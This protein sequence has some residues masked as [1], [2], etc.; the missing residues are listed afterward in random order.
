MRRTGFAFFAVGVGCTALLVSA[1]SS[2]CRS[3]SPVPLVPEGQGGDT[4]SV[5]AHASSTTGS[6]ATTSATGAGGASGATTT[7]TTGAPDTTTVASGSGGGAAVT[8]SGTTTT[9]A[10]SGSGGSNSACTGIS[11]TIADITGAT[12]GSGVQVTVTGVVAMSQKFLVDKSSKGSCLW[13]LFVSAPGLTT[14]AP[15]SGLLVLSYGTDATVSASTGKSFCP[16]LGTDPIGDKLPDATKPGDVLTL[17]GKAADF[18]LTNCATQVG[19]T[20][21]GQF[22]ISNVCAA[23]KTGTAAVPAPAKLSAADLASLAGQTDKTFYDKWGGVKVEIDSVTAVNAAATGGGGAGGGGSAAGK[24]EDSFGNIVL[25]NGL[26]LPDKIYYQGYNT[27]DLCHAG[28]TFVGSS[29]PF[30][31]IAGFPTVNFCTWNLYVDNKCA[32]FDPAS[33]DCTAGTMCP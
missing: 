29:V 1:A 23:T 16:E 31:S 8:S 18:L 6:G 3:N 13:G 20:M 7:A 26:Q 10:T 19:G 17:S 30:A 21:I 25:D 15:G 9:S 28:P 12:V 4:S 22:Q 5:G 2:G 11:A 27:A 14:T 24:L 32:D 33:P